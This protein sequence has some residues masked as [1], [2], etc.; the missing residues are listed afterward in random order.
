MKLEI[1]MNWHPLNTWIKGK[2]R[3]VTALLIC[4]GPQEK[5]DKFFQGVQ[6]ISVDS[7]HITKQGLIHVRK[8]SIK[9]KYYDSLYD[10]ELIFAK[11][12]LHKNGLEYTEIYSWS[13]KPLA[14]LLLSR[15][16]DRN[17]EVLELQQFVKEKSSGLHLLSVAPD[18]TSHQHDIFQFTASNGYYNHPRKITLDDLSKMKKLS[19]SA[20]HDALRRAES[21]LFQQF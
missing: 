20:Y 8:T 21:H 4:N 6:K 17:T 9:N 7:E 3:F 5:I 18:L 14:Q 1:S 11:P 10:P 16:N 2:S 13:K 19:K 12:I 15:R